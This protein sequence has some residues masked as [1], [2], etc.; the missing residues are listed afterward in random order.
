VGSV[1]RATPRVRTIERLLTEWNPVGHATNSQYPT[2]AAMEIPM[3]RASDP[4]TRRDAPGRRLAISILAVAMVTT[5]CG[6]EPAAPSAAAIAPTSPAV[7]P[8]TTARPSPT[9]APAAVPGGRLVYARFVDDRGSVFTINPDGTDMK[10]LVLPG[11]VAPRWSPD[12]RRISVAEDNAQGQLSIGLADREGHDYVLFDSPDPTLGL[13]GMAWSPDGSRLAAEA[14]DDSDVTRNGI[15]TVRAS[16]GGDLIRV[17]SCPDG[18]HDIPGDYSPDGRQIVFAREKLPDQADTT[19]M[20]V[21]VD[22]SHARPI[23]AQKVGGSGRWSPDGKTILATVGEDRN[24]S[25]LL[26]PIDG[27]TATKFEIA[28]D[29]TLKPFG[30]SWSPDGEWIVFSA[31]NETSVDLY[32]ARTDGTDLHQ[33]TD[34][35]RNWEDGADWK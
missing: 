7:S 24:G 31:R 16:D 34:T 2:L 29:P 10:P 17:T 5:A 1:G 21:D 9:V 6:G 33:V 11:G 15:Y 20:V 35:P 14:F 4:V 27:G 28:S 19:L 18:C 32:V 8:T 13:A 25:L 12:G 30:G 26:V 23:T 22:G 3:V